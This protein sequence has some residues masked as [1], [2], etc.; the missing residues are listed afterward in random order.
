MPDKQKNG[1]TRFII[2]TWGAISIVALVAWFLAPYWVPQ[3]HSDQFEALSALFN[4]LAFAG[5]I[6]AIFLQR[7]DLKLQTQ[8]LAKTNEQLK[9][10]ANALED[11]AE[12]LNKQNFEST[13]FHMIQ[14]HHS[15][16]DGM[17]SYDHRA[18]EK[19]GRLVFELL[20]QGLRQKAQGGDYEA[21]QAAIKEGVRSN[22]LI[23]DHYVTNFYCMLQ[24]VDSSTVEHTLYVR[25]IKAQLSTW[26]LFIL[27][28]A[29][30]FGTGEWIELASRH[31]LF[32]GI[33]S[34]RLVRGEED[35][36]E[37]QTQSARF[38]GLR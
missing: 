5:L 38:R 17:R 9:I 6:A 23:V 20:I 8:E 12:A 1:S 14:L 15:I 37:Y 31:L 27:F 21:H 28:Y 26:E 22:S 4:G 24:Y 3:G 11:Q 7:K 34:Q 16:V 35:L 10:Q 18:R 13:F 29:T 19:V 2:G 32:D 36:V 30:F 33:D 25:I